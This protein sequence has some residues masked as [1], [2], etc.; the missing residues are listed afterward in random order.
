[1][2]TLTLTL[3]M[4]DPKLWANRNT[5]WRAKGPIAK[6]HRQNACWVTLAQMGVLGISP[7]WPAATISFVF[8]FKD[9]RKRDVLNAAQ[10]MKASI[11]GIV[12]A[13]LIPDDDHV[14]LDVGTITGGIDR[15]NPRV[16]IT[17][18]RKELE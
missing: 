18:K 7:V 8:W 15:K 13:G 4:P 3:P 9:K 6:S 16:E 1:M 10:A 12:D 2:N 11:D 14:H 5:H 17:L